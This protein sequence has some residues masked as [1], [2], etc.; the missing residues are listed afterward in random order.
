MSDD[1]FAE[2]ENYDT[3]IRVIRSYT[4]R[5]YWAIIRDKCLSIAEM[6]YCAFQFKISTKKTTSRFLPVDS[7]FALYF[8]TFIMIIVLLNSVQIT[9]Q[10]VGFFK[11][12]HPFM[13][14]PAIE[15]RFSRILDF[16]FFFVYMSEFVIKLIGLGPREYFCGAS[17]LSNIFDFIL[18]LFGMEWL[19][20]IE[21]YQQPNIS[22]IATNCQ[23]LQKRDQE[24]A[25]WL[26]TT[27]YLNA[28]Y[29]ND[30]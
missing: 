24:S 23:A 19:D 22:A 12:C 15:H 14:D 21:S 8:E 11:Y 10:T 29:S 28:H 27:R 25:I 7:T 16:F 30:L 5:Y 17:N 20:M 1:L 2:M 3:N 4:F 26:G 6:K 18:L 9:F 13:N